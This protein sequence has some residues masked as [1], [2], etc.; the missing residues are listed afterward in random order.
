MTGPALRPLGI[1]EILDV[2]IKAYLRNA[3]TLIGLAAVVVVPFQILSAIVLLSVVPDAN[4]VPR[5]TFG[6]TSSTTTDAAA[7]LG[8]SATL[9]ITG[10]LVGLLV[11]AACLKAVS[12]IYLDRPA[13]FGGSLRFAVRRL[14]PLVWMNVLMGVGLLFAF[15]ALII[16]GIWLYV[17]WSL[18]TPALL[19]ENLRGRRALGRSYRLVKGRWWRTAGVLLVA[20]ILVTFVAGVIQGVLV[21]VA[22]SSSGSVLV[23]VTVVSLAA[24]LSSLLTQPFHAAVVTVLY[25]DLRVRREGFDIALLAEQLGIEPAELPA[26]ATPPAGPESVGKPGGPPFWPPPPGWSE[27]S[28]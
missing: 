10:F 23:A 14:G 7:R 27:H 8:A 25:Y 9:T 13:D 22:L 26:G 16:P 4:S 3:K 6:S 17:A 28:V 20:N 5:G 18:A 21:A 12:D 11:T 2:G 15:V 1:G 19:I 24:A